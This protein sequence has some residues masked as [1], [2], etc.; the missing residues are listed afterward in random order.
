MGFVDS[1]G[2]S[3]FD[4]KVLDGVHDGNSRFLTG[5]EYSRF[6]GLLA[7][8]MHIGTRDR[9]LGMGMMLYSSRV[10]KVRTEFCG[11]RRNYIVL[12]IRSYS[13]LLCS[14][15]KVLPG[16]SWGDGLLLLR[17][18]YSAYLKIL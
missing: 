14:F 4:F 8:L 11:F 6:S 7:V 17:I 18:A 16:L 1:R 15:R 12:L 9:A 2:Y 10:L 5:R 3:W 13:Q